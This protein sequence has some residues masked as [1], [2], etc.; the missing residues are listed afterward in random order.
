MKDQNGVKMKG[1]HLLVKGTNVSIDV[2]DN[3]LWEKVFDES[4]ILSGTTKVR[5]L[6]IVNFPVK[7]ITAFLV[8][9]ESH[10]SVHTYPENDGYYFDI[11]SCKQ[12]DTQP[13]IKLL[14]EVFGN[15]DIIDIIVER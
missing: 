8:L 12:F 2:D 7:G 6:E 4:V 3:T 1:K 9:G 5:D 14:L 11:F 10:I 13:V 15:H